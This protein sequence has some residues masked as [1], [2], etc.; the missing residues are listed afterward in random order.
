MC[1]T[2]A[3]SDNIVRLGGR[4]YTQRM[5]MSNP[6][7]ISRL[8]LARLNNDLDILYEKLYFFWN[9]FTEK[10]FLI[11]LPQLTI[12]LET[13]NDLLKAYKKITLKSDTG[14]QTDRLK[15]IY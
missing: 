7:G 4:T 6:G 3:I 9:S 5:R 14:L 10:D 2:S 15:K 1:R 8:K 11:I 12:L 13:I